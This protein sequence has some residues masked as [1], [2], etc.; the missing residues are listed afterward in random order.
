MSSALREIVAR[1]LTDTCTI[2]RTTTVAFDP[3]TFQ[4]VATAGS[5]VYEGP[6][7][8]RPLAAEQVAVGEASVPSRTHNVWLPWD[9]VT[10]KAGHVLTV[11]DSDDPYMIDRTFTVT[12]VEGGTGTAYR[13]LGA[14]EMLDVDEGEAA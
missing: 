13:K 9:T 5:A 4:D 2:G 10:V 14:V 6:C 7:R 8:V 3:E 12:E 1:W 11:T